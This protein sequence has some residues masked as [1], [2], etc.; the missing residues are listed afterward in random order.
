MGRGG[1]ERK[2]ARPPNYATAALLPMDLPNCFA[3]IH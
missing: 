1:E 3:P 2:G